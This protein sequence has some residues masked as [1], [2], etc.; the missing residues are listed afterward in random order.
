MT[1]LKPT[2]QNKALQQVT[3]RDYGG[4]LNT[5]DSDFNLSSRY[6]VDGYNTMPDDNGAL[7]VRW[8]TRLFA[9]FSSV[10]TD[11]IVGVQY[12]FSY[13]IAVCANGT[14]AASDGAGNVVLI[15]SNDIA[16]RLPGAP[17]GWGPT[18][19]AN[20]TQFLGEL[21]VVNG[22]DKPLVINNSLNVRYLQDLGSGSN[23]NVPVCKYVAV[24]SNYVV[25]AGDPIK[26]GR[27]HI[28]NAGTSGTWVGDALPNDSVNF[29]VDKYAPDSTGEIVG[30]VSFR[31]KLVVFFSEYILTVK[32]GT[33]NTATPPVHTP[34]VDDLI[35][36]YG[37]VSHKAIIN[38][39]EQVIFLDYTGAASIKNA[40]FTNQIT[41]TR[42]STLVDVNLQTALGSLSRSFLQ[43][44][45]FSLYDKRENR[46]IFVI[47]KSEFTGTNPALEQNVYALS[48]RKG[49]YVWNRWKN[50]TFQTG[51][52][53]VE[54][55][56]FFASGTYMYRYGSAKEPILSDYEGVNPYDG[57]PE[58]KCS[59]YVRGIRCD[60]STLATGIDFYHSLPLSELKD[61]TSWKTLHYI[62]MDTEGASPFTVYL[63]YDDL[64]KRDA[65]VGDTWSDG[66][67]F[68]DSF[69]WKS[70]SILSHASMSFV[71]GDRGADSLTV[72]AQGTPYRPT[73]NM[74]LYAIYGRFRFIRVAYAGK[75][76]SHFKLVSTSL[77]YTKGSIY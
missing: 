7:Q 8:G 71:A 74:M 49:Q 23:L 25:M 61:R 55:R 68:T 56:L 17:I 46:I 75:S 43:D 70:N 40:T 66:T 37:A 20:F 64:A 53:S 4:G 27:L 62:T 10:L 31:D 77:Y 41:P 3:A 18:V 52:V 50:W 39:G 67:L 38:A 60:A 58:D 44:N 57:Q 21:I 45:V 26:P 54:G 36:S 76:H 30:M 1:K 5:A 13:L 47:P 65:G 33:Y 59:V 16:L 63:N 72:P 42:I 11:R 48:I 35:T 9:Q 22:T 32:L 69:G 29:D 51:T 24:H 15:W 34:I 28:S 73:D 2:L 19:R 6:H 14:I 12:Y